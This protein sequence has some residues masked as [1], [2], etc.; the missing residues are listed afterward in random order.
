[1]A[2]D[3]GDRYQ[4]AGEMGNDIQRALQGMPVAAATRAVGYEGTRRMGPA[5][6]MAGAT[7]AIPPYDYG[8]GDGPP[9]REGRK[10]WPWVVAALVAVAIIAGLVYAVSYVSGGGSSYSV[11]NVVNLPLA[12]AQQDIANAHLVSQVTRQASST[13]PKNDVISTSPPFGT[14]VAK[15]STVKLVVSTG[16]GT[17]SVPNV[18]GQTATAATS[19]L[20]AKG[21]QVNQKPAPN[22]TQPKG[23]VVG[24][25]PPAGANVAPNSTVTIDVS[26]GGAQVPSVIGD[27]VGTAQQILSNAGFNVVTRTVAGPSGSTPGNVFSQNPSGGTLPQGGTVTIYVASQPTPSPTPSPTPTQ[28]SPSPTSSPS[29]TGP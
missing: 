14:T 19:A 17:V 21:L 11:P 1:M 15:G 22:S 3:P 16:A 10:K 12:T 8:P 5:T 7:S 18:L 9:E 25:N 6:R 29:S 24:Q 27:P 20:A 26:G 2:K 28:S 13:V 23:T 4:S